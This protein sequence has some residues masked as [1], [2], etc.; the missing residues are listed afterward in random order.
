MNLVFLGPPGAGK[1]TLAGLAAPY[2]N[3][4]HISTGAIFRKAIAAGTQ[5]GIRI[6]ANID[7]GGL[8]DDPTTIKLVSERLTLD[9]AK[10]GYILDGFPRDIVQAKALDTFSKV[11]KV[12]D[13]DIDDDGVLA[14]LAG[15]RV[16]R[17]CGFNWHITFNPPKIANICDK[18]GGEVYIRDDDKKESVKKR[19]EVYRKVTAPLIAYYRGKGILV[20]IDSRGGI[21]PIFAAFKRIF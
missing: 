17:K 5:L 3:I 11:D 16:C 20:N 8:V 2:L 7:A 19:L 12:I 21:E 6:K 10:K 9:D 14:R 1:G 4:P 13:F 18:C 15:R